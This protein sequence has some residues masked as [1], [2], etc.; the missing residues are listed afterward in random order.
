MF[1][2]IKDYINSLYCVFGGHKSSCNS[3]IAYNIDTDYMRAKIKT[4]RITVCKRCHKIVC[5]EIDNYNKYGWY[6]S[7]LAE[8]EEK[9]LRKQ[10]LVTISEAYKEIEEKGTSPMSLRGTMY[11]QSAE[12]RIS[13]I[14]Q[15]HLHSSKLMRTTRLVMC[16]QTGKGVNVSINANQ[17]SQVMLKFFAEIVNLF[18]RPR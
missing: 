17:L 12:V 6:N 3:I 13:Y 7:Y 10:G 5:Y 18:F 15:Q 14:L 4:Y 1:K 16:W 11:V 8:I 9:K 2:S